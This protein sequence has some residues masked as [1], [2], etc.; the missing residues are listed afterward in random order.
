MIKNCVICNTPFEA[1]RADAE[2]CSSACR[3]KNWRKKTQEQTEPKDLASQVSYTGVIPPLD[4]S[5]VVNYD[6]EREAKLISLQLENQSLKNKI[7]EW[8]EKYKALGDKYDQLLKGKQ[9]KGVIEDISAPGDIVVTD[10]ESGNRTSLRDYLGL[11]D[12]P[13]TAKFAQERA[14]SK[15]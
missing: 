13:G 6:P 12:K 1:K 2:V 9:R 5:P 11:D 14:K 4:Q 15:Q 3:Q 7:I 8:E 10:S